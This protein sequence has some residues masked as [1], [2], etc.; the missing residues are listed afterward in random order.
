MKDLTIRYNYEH[1]QTTPG[2]HDSDGC[3]EPL[4]RSIN[5][6]LAIVRMLNSSYNHA[7]E[8]TPFK[9][10]FDTQYTRTYGIQRIKDDNVWLKPVNGD[11]WGLEKGK[12]EKPDAEEVCSSQG[13]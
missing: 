13:G 2:N 5:E 4:H 3:V 8:D 1:Y 11:E 10:M 7:I 9:I 12:R 6:N